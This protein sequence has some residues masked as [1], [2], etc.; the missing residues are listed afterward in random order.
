LQILGRFDEALVWTDRSLSIAPG[1]STPMRFRM[2]ILAGMGR[3]DEAR[4]VYKEYYAL[5]G[6]QVRSIAEYR[7]FA[8]RIWPATDPIS[9]AARERVI[10]GLRKAG[11]PDQ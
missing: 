10:D 9:V 6:K 3:L 11:M 8:S 7:S 5:P 2:A 4:E 1:V